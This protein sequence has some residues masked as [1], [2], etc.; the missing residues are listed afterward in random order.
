MALLYFTFVFFQDVESYIHRS[1][2]TGRAGRDG[3][4]VLFFK[5]NEEY[6]LAYVEQ[7][8]VS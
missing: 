8:A 6:N 5:P 7:K 2:R 1:G 3:T 4:C